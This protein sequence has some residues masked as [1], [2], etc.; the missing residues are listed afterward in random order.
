M[1][2]EYEAT[3]P[4][5]NKEQIRIK[6]KS[7]GADLI[8][9][10]TLQK[11]INFYP[12]VEINGDS[13]V[14]VRDEGNIV[15]M[16]FKTVPDKTNNIEDQEEICLKVDNF[17]EARNFLLSLGCK[18]KSYQETKREAWNLNNVEITLNEW[19]FLKPFLEIESHSEGAV[20]K[21][22]ELLGF[23][24]QE[25]LFCNVFY[26]YSE[27]YGIPIE[28]LKNRIKGELSELTFSSENPFIKN[29]RF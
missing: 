21:A 24:Y 13:W 20:K 27:Q 5:I 9:T 22:C 28:E 8:F 2:I 17:E 29:K 19:P 18:E 14:R 25:A 26:L 15:T 23:N 7:L 10:E 1:A 3:F 16:S 11:R 6:L 12:L 4:S